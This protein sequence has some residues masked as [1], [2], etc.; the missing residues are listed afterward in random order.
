MIK[1]LPDTFSWIADYTGCADAGFSGEGFRDKVCAAILQ[2]V[3][4]ARA[5]IVYGSALSGTLNRFSDLDALCVTGGPDRLEKHQFIIDGIMF[6]VGV[7]SFSLLPRVKELTLRFGRPIG[8]FAL[9]HGEIWF[10]HI[11]GFDMVK[12]NAQDFVRNHKKPKTNAQ[13]MAKRA[14]L[15]SLMNVAKSKTD[16]ARTI[17]AIVL[18]NKLAQYYVNTALNTSQPSHSAIE[19]FDSPDHINTLKSLM[20]P[21]LTSDWEQF[22][23]LVRATLFETSLQWDRTSKLI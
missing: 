3:I 13:E 16:H 22:S 9:A 8:L 23:T 7:I 20:Q 19:Q 11:P 18:V 1:I 5:I 14:I 21:I 10:G 12:A 2:R 17:D 15:R 6:D 4:E